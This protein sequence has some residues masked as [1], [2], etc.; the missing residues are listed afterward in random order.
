M[1]PNWKLSALSP[2]VLLSLQWSQPLDD[3]TSENKISDKNSLNLV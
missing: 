3:D 2:H 1:L